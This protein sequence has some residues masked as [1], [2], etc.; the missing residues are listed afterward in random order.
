MMRWKRKNEFNQSHLLHEEKGKEIFEFQA[1]LSR[2][3]PNI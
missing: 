2:Q 1:K 3:V